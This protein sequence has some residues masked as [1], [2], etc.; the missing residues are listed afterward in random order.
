MLDLGIKEESGS[1]AGFI[2]ILQKKLY[3]MLNL[4]S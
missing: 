2:S 3:R 1:H 4:D